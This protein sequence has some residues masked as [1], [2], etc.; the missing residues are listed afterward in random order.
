MQLVH[1]GFPSGDPLDIRLDH[2]FHQVQWKSLRVFGI[3]SWRLNAD[4]IIDMAVRHSETLRGLRLRDVLL[5]QGSR[6]KDVLSALRDEMQALEWISLRRI[7]YATHF[8]EMMQGT[9]ILDVDLYPSSESTA[10]S[11]EEILAPNEDHRD[12]EEISLHD[13]SE[14]DLE[15]DQSDR[16]SD[17]ALESVR[18][19]SPAVTSLTSTMRS[20]T[21]QSIASIPADELG[22]DGKSIAR[23]QIT[24]A[25]EHWVIAPRKV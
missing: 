25:W 6:W 24:K 23:R 1:I 13:D 14:E 2:I 19:E 22:D 7:D 18:S 17:H 11:E 3:Q 12:S 16:L 5:N 20:F 10:D 15:D 9:E 21:L 4:E 8:D